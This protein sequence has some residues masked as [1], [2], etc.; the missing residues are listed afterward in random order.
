MYDFSKDGTA[1]VNKICEDNITKSVSAVIDKQGNIIIPF[2]YSFI[3]NPWQGIRVASPQD[4]EG[5]GKSSG[6]IDSSGNWLV[7]PIYFEMGNIKDGLVIACIVREEVGYEGIL[8]M[9]GS[10]LFEPIHNGVYSFKNNMIVFEDMCNSGIDPNIMMLYDLKGN[11]LLKGKTFNKID[12][13]TENLVLCSNYLNS[14]GNMNFQVY[15]AD[16]SLL[17]TEDMLRYAYQLENGVIV[18]CVGESPYATRWGIP[19]LNGGWLI[20]PLYYK[21]LTFNGD[22]GAGIRIIDDKST[23]DKIVFVTEIFNQNG[24]VI[25]SSQEEYMDYD[26]FIKIPWVENWVN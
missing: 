18:A 7:E 10:W 8:K 21:I 11:Q 6:L 14:E 15:Y 17:V 22:K 24:E 19:D 5:T 2:N 23:N 12:I 1:V 9:D 20:P 3:S 25:Y 26:N 4:E 13:L 16:G